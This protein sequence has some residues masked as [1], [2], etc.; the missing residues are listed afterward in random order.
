[1]ANDELKVVAVLNQIDGF[2]HAR[3][4]SVGVP[5]IFGMNFQSAN[6]GQKFSGYV[7]SAGAV[8]QTITTLGA[9]NG[10]TPG[11][12]QALD[13]VDAAVGRMIARLDA[14]DLTDFT[15]L[16]VTAKHA[17]SLVDRST[18][19]PIDPAGFAPLINNNV[20][21]GLTAQV[22]ADT[23]ALIWLKDRDRAADAAEVLEAHAADIGAEN[24]F[25]GT[26]IE[27][28]FGGP[29]AGN[30]G[31]RPDVVVQPVP[32]VV[33]TTVGAKLCD[34]AGSHPEDIHVPLVVVDPRREPGTVDCAV[35][36]RQIAP[37]I[38]HALKLK[39]RDLDAVRLENTRKLPQAD[40]DLC[41]ADDDDSADEG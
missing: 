6:I 34:H 27:T 37:S 39:T 23:L 3:A 16:I 22:T 29:L 8:P 19:R 25:A 1:M 32:G 26:E 4:A 9:Q 17:N 31:R 40:G 11:L 35:S 2:D 36:L 41:E 33:Y 12:A 24:I 28:I 15:V 30:P 20:Q 5:A 21:A 7:D 14:N 13:Y 18:L 38:L 10:K